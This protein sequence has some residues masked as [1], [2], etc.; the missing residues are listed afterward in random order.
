MSEEPLA[1][2]LLR[3]EELSEQGQEV[4]AE[5][6]CRS[7]PQHAQELSRRMQA[8]KA[9]SWVKETVEVAD[10]AAASRSDEKAPG[11]GGAQPSRILADRY[12]LDQRLG[13][14]AFGEVWSAYDL[15]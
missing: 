13:V 15:E 1:D 5:E 7:C 9:M 14:G 11:G 3:W 4:S 2:L 8:L 10:R 12:R 6:L